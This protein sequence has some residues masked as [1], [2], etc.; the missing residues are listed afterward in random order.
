[1]GKLSLLM[2]ALS[3]RLEVEQKGLNMNTF[4]PYRSFV[5]S[6]RCLDYRRLGKQRVEAMQILNTL[7]GKK[8]GWVNHPAVLMWKGFEDALRLYLK[9][10]INE[11]IDRGYKNNMEI[12][13]FDSIFGIEFPSF[14]GNKEFHASHRS[15]LLRKNKEWYSQFNWT[16]TDDLPYIWPVRKGQ[17]QD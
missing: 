1:M 13:Y 9:V 2:C 12:P 14:I 7:Y 11:W 17:L 4:L 8:Q 5:N 16:E 3:K 6:A 15:N 10:V